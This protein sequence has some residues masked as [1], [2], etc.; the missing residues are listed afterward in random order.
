MLWLL[1]IAANF[2]LDG[3]FA[4]LGPYV[5]EPWPR[6]LRASGHG[7]VYG[8]GSLGRMLGPMVLGLLAGGGNLV[9]PR[10]TMAAL[11][12]AFLFWGLTV[13]GVAIV[14]L[15]GYETKGKTLEEIERMVTRGKTGSAQ[16]LTR[17][18]AANGNATGS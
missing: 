1:M 17:G 11:F 18:A 16:E 13:Y 8:I 6:H 14:F 7:L 2:F 5:S 9:T 4:I 12:P 10:A 3:A 15:F